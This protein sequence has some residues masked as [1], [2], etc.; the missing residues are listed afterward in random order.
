MRIRVPKLVVR[1]C[2]APL[3]APA[4]ALA[5]SGAHAGDGGNAPRMERTD[6]VNEMVDPTREIVR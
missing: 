2:L 1:V 5:S 3:A 4:S 6:L